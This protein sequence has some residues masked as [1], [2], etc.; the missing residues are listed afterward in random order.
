MIKPWTL[1]WVIECNWEANMSHLEDHE[2]LSII[3]NI[4]ESE[5]GFRLLVGKYK[6][7]LYYLIRRMVLSHDDADDI[8][9]NTFI[10][11]FRGIEG[12]E[13]N[14]QLFTWLY[15]IATNETLTFIEQKKRKKTETID[16]PD[17]GLVGSFSCFSIAASSDW[18]RCRSCSW[19]CER[20]WSVERS[21]MELVRPLMDCSRRLSSCCFSCCLKKICS[22]NHRW[23]TY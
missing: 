19:F 7:R 10:K 12:F 9:Q 4:T 20:A 14:S 22:K 5:R 23:C 13:G 6:E 17:L 15:R 2:I 18:I 11:V 8:L 16:N 1:I 3:K 21:C